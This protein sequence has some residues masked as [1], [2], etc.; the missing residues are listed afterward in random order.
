MTR[1]AA[2]RP[3]RSG[4]PW[5]GIKIICRPLRPMAMAST[6]GGSP[7][8]RHG[9][10][11]RDDLGD[12]GG[13]VAHAL[14]I[15]DHLHGRG[16]GAGR[17]PRAAGGAAGSCSGAR[18]PAHVVDAVIPPAR[19]S[20]RLRCRRAVQRFQR[21]LHGLGGVLPHLHQCGLEGSRSLSYCLR[22]LI[23]LF[24]PCINR[25]GRKYNP[26]CACPGVC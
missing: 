9:D 26:L 23:A 11:M 15:G 16:D 12:I 25:T 17:P 10:K 2:A 8:L 19:S 24:L 6:D 5:R 3:R 7:S 21:V 20:G 18:C 1:R 14:D 13:V 22:M 4:Q